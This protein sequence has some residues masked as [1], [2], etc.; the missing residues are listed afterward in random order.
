MMRLKVCL[1]LVFTLI[2]GLAYG[3]G[4]GQQDNS[5]IRTILIIYVSNSGNTEKLAD[6]ITRE[7]PALTL[8]LGSKTPS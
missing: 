6:S 3:V 7:H 1:K 4:F 2:V 5:Q 8:Q